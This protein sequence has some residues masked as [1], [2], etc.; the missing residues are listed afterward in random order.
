[1]TRKSGD[2]AAVIGVALMLLASCAVAAE[3]DLTS[4]DGPYALFLPSVVDYGVELY[5]VEVNRSATRFGES[6]KVRISPGTQQLAIQLE[7]QPAAGTSLIV[8]GIGNLFLRSAT[9]KTF[10][11]DLS[12]DVHANH[13]YHLSARTNTAGGFDITVFDESLGKEVAKQS[14]TEKDGR[15][16]RLF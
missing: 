16:E 2:C 14:F 1:M 11:T 3:R 9:N 7:Y 5:V 4:G 12:V 13:I 8:G 15:F 10:R 6:D